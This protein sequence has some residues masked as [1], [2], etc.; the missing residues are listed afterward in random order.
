MTFKENQRLGFWDI[1]W[2]VYQE[3]IALD[4]YRIHCKAP[5]DPKIVEHFVH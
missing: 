2:W 4:D 1:V 5:R 3:K